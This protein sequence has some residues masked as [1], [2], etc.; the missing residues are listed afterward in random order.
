MMSRY[1]A[2]T[3]GAMVAVVVLLTATNPAQAA[4]TIYTDRA[5]FNAATT[6]TTIDFEE[7][8]S[9]GFTLYGNTGLTRGG[10][11]FRG[12]LDGGSDRLFTVDPDYF[13]PF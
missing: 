1:W 10:A 4:F 6:T 13:A 2:H 7:N 8:A 5:T 11:N 3:L 9:G 12:I